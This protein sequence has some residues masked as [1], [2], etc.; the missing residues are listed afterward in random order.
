MVDQKAPVLTLVCLLA[1]IVISDCAA[2]GTSLHARAE[3]GHAISQFNLGVAY[4]LGKGVPQDHEKA[5]YWYS[6][7]AEQGDPPAQYNLGL[8]YQEGKS[9]PQDYKKAVYWHTKAAEHGDTGAQFNLGVAHERGKGAP[10]NNQKAVYWYTKAAEQGHARSQYNLGLMH[11]QGQGVSQ[12]NEGALVWWGKAA[13]QGFS[14]AQNNLGSMY[15]KGKGI[16]QDDKKA[17][18]WYAKAAEQGHASSQYNLGLMYYQGQGI[19]QDDKKAFEWWNKAAEQGFAVAQNNLGSMYAKGKGVSQD[20]KKAVYWYAKA[21]AQGLGFAKTHLNR[22]KGEI[23]E[24]SRVGEHQKNTSPN[25]VEPVKK[26]KQGIDNNKVF[27]AASGTGFIVSGNGHLITNS[28]VINGCDKV[29]AHQNGID[30]P[31]TVIATDQV[32]DLALLKTD[33]N[34]KTIFPLSNINAHLM[35][36]VFLAGFPF[37]KSISSSMKITKGIVSSLSGLRNNYSNMQIDAA[38]Q[39]GNSGGP[40]IDD[41]GNVVGVAVAKLDLAKVVEEWGVVPEGTNFSVKSSV[42]RNFMESNGVVALKPRTNP[43][44]KQKLARQVTDGTLYLSCWMT[45]TKIKQMQSQKVMFTNFE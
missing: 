30:Y 16:P 15:A 10:K 44:S 34:P 14:D 40:V 27:A 38:L 43:I 25:E 13:E 7:S 20:D 41:K 12:D 19:P 3:Q 9:V 28:H 5:F 33:I 29:K 6:K 39:P 23:Q 32:N 8:M 31:L 2:K 26:S 11:Y 35:Q 18:Y 42:V 24:R 37:G 22:A 4:E 21:A 1:N 45:Y 17:V 36:D